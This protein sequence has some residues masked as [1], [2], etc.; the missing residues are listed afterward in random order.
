MSPPNRGKPPPSVRR[1]P[2]FYEILVPIALGLIALAIVILLLIIAGMV[3]G[4][5]STAR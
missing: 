2:P 3:W 4:M 5:L 1:Y